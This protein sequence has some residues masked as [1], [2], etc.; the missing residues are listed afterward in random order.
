M[1]YPPAAPP[2]RPAAWLPDPLD[3]ALVRYWDGQRWTFHTAV[4][5][6]DAPAPV[7]EQT[8]KPAQPA[9]RPDVAA[10]VNRVRGMLVGS[11][12]EVNLLGGYLGAEEQVLALTGAAGEGQGVL[13]CTN[14]RLLFLFVG[15]I[16]RQ[17]IQI[18]WN[19]AK[20][21]VYDRTSR[22]FLVYVTKPTKR[23]VPAFAV[24]VGNLSD[25]QVV[26]QA[27]QAAAAAPRL[28]VV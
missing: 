2:V 10:A 5:Q 11:M 22:M 21:V 24:R 1:T 3:D 6:V 25:A 12:K 16:R 7:A 23:A 26:A 8:I 9:L 28:D 19:Q 18:G 15:V 17:F 27:A 4:R 13:V 20:A 14:Q